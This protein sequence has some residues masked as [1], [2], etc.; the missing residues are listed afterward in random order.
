M[1]EDFRICTL[2]W[3]CTDLCSMYSTYNNFYGRLCTR[4]KQ[5]K[6]DWF[7]P[8]TYIVPEPG[9]GKHKF[10]SAE[11]VKPLTPVPGMQIRLPDLYQ[12]LYCAVACSRY[13][14]QVQYPVLVHTSTVVRPGTYEPVFA[15]PNIGTYLYKVPGTSTQ[16]WYIPILRPGTSYQVVPIR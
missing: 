4:G 12:V 11:P 3:F 7:K 9:T 15:Y 13:Q 1:P 16:Y 5:T 10:K 14:V 8:S 2:D 6:N